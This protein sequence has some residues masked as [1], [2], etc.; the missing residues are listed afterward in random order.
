MSITIEQRVEAVV[1]EVRNFGQ[2]MSALE[3]AEFIEQ[4]AF[5]LM[6]ERD[7]IE[8]CMDKR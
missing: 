3:Y 6:E 2:S 7:G 8:P 4:V 1:H 5:A